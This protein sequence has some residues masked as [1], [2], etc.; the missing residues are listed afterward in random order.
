M[1]ENKIASKLCNK[2]T[3][4]MMARWLRYVLAQS[5]LANQINVNNFLPIRDF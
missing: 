1:T 3:E 4:H 2:R 5:E